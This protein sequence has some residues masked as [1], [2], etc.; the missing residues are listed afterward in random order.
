MPDWLVHLKYG[1]PITDLTLTKEHEKFCHGQIVSKKTH[2]K[3]KNI[4][5]QWK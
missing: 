3:Q 1:W 2:K 4:I 5:D